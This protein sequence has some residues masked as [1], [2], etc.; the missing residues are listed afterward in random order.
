MGE[1]EHKNSSSRPMKKIHFE[2]ENTQ[3]LAVKPSLNNAQEAKM[4]F[5][6]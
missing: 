1:E 5:L 3:S 6:L 4:T 2:Q